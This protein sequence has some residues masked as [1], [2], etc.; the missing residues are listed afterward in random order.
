[1]S[2]ALR[3]LHLIGVCLF[4]GSI[5]AHI[6]LGAVADPA[7]DPVTF[8]ATIAGKDLLTRTLTLAGLVIAGVTGV[9][10]A[11]ARGG[12]LSRRWLRVKVLLVALAA[13][14]GGLLL[15]PIAGEMAM[16]AARAV[17]TGV[18]DPAFA[19]L[20]AREAPLGALNLVLIVAVLALAVWRP[21]LGEKR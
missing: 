10:L 6:L 12:V 2:K 18:L 7:G 15:T 4:V 20:T 11:F 21:R 5:P 19:K 8:A 16:L 13:L 17:D 1:M 3:L 14:N 9:A